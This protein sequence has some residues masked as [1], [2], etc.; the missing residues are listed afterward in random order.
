MKMQPHPWWLTKLDWIVNWSRCSSL[1]MMP[2]NEIMHARGYLHSYYGAV[3]IDI[4]LTLFIAYLIVPH[5]GRWLRKRHRDGKSRA[6]WY[7]FAGEDVLRAPKYHGWAIFSA[8]LGTLSHVTIDLF[9][10]EY[11]PVFW[12]YRLSKYDNLMPFDD[13]MLSSLTFI[14]ALG[15]IIL[16]MLLK[17]WTKE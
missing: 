10:H 5:F 15:A 2:F 6:K 16:Y 12:P 7:M 9:T 13:Y 3:T 4:A 17:Y 8:L 11:N 1:W 14:T